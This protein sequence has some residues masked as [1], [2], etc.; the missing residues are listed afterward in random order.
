MTKNR[1]HR[2]SHLL[3]SIEGLP[4]DRSFSDGQPHIE[5]KKYEHSA[6]QKR[7]TPPEGKKLLVG[8]PTGKQQEDAAGEEESDWG[9]ELREHSIPGALVRRSIFDR[10]Q[11]RA[12]PPATET[13]SLAKSA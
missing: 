1:P 3:A 7:K 5:A 4:E 9:S 8:E 10:K 6:R 13:K 2:H 12:A 11:H